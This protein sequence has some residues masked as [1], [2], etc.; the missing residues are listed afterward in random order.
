MPVRK[1]SVIKICL[2]LI[3]ASDCSR[4]LHILTKYRRQLDE[5]T[6][7]SFRN[8]VD[9]LINTLESQLFSSLMGKLSL[10]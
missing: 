7:R 10:F 6:D 9:K 5:K 1:G 4:A 8:A 3:Y 2:F